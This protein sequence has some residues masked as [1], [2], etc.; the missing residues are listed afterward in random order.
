MIFEVMA[1]IWINYAIDRVVEDVRQDGV[2]Q[3]I[4]ALS[5]QI[6]EAH[7]DFVLFDTQCLGS[8]Q[9]VLFMDLP[10]LYNTDTR[11]HS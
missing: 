5:G 11:H 6:S 3:I 10:I 7:L 8:I 9:G 2:G 4:R 1:F